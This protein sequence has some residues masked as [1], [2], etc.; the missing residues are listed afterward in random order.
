[1]CPDRDNLAELQDNLVEP[2]TFQ[3]LLESRSCNT[4]YFLSLL[5]SKAE[6]DLI[7]AEGPRP[8]SGPTCTKKYAAKGRGSP[9]YVKQ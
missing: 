8:Y 9:S 6:D 1:M 3:S 5:E 2:A 7:L 4:A